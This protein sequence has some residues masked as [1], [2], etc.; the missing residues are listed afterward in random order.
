M[1]RQMPEMDGL[2]ATRMIRHISGSAST[3]WIIAMTA[4]AQEDEK[5]EYLDSGAN[6]FIAKQSDI[7]ALQ[8]RMREY[9]RQ[10]ESEGQG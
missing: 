6:D 4:S 2:T 5:Q 8:E 9:Q 3:P 10:Q 1:D 7:N